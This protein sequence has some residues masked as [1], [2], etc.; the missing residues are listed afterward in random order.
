MISFE[1]S[2]TDG[3]HDIRLVLNLFLYLEL[4]SVLYASFPFLTTDKPLAA[5]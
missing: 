2:G 3:F 4:K 1:F 5:Q